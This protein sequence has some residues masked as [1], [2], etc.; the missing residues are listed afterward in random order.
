M[1]RL[2]KKRGKIPFQFVSILNVTIAASESLIAFP[3]NSKILSFSFKKIWFLVLV[4]CVLTCLRGSFE[5]LVSCKTLK[6]PARSKQERISQSVWPGSRRRRT[7]LR[8]PDPRDLFQNRN[9]QGSDFLQDR[10]PGLSVSPSPSETKEKCI[11]H[12]FP[13]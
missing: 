12:P 3:L 2:K 9:P 6:M 11:F 5:T 8:F 4:I 10:D 7:K 1:L 13:E